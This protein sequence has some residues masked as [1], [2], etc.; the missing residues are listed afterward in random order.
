MIMP[1]VGLYL[2]SDI[3]GLR[4]VLM[5]A[6]VADDSLISRSLPLHTSG[7]RMLHVLILLPHISCCCSHGP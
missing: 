5:G 3:F 4:L 1:H 2:L 6:R 7:Y